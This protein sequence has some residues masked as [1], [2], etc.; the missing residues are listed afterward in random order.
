MHTAGYKDVII[1]A[2]MNYMVPT[3]YFKVGC[4]QQLVDVITPAL[5]P[6]WLGDATAE[7]A[8]DSIKDA[9]QDVWDE[10]QAKYGG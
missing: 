1:D 7:E 10:Y 6:V 5:D 3:G 4:W 2:T 8:I 9:A